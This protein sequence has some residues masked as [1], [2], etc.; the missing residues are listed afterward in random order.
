MTP[1]AVEKTG[2]PT[3]ECIKCGECISACPNNSVDLYI[4]GTNIKARSWFM[5]LTVA[6]GFTLYMWFVLMI[7]QL[8]PR[9]IS[10]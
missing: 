7:I 3:L 5:P 4:H 9:L 8:I 1:K 2:K 6:A 10:L